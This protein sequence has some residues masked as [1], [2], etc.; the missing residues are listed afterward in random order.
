MKLHEE[1]SKKQAKDT[2][3][4]MPTETWGLIPTSRSTGA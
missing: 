2:N 1:K 3:S 4:E